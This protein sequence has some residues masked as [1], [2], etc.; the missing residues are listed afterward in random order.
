[1]C[2]LGHE[3]Q[4]D[5]EIFDARAPAN[6]PP[7]ENT[8]TFWCIVLPPFPSALP[9]L[10]RE[11]IRSVRQCKTSAEERALIAKESAAIRSSLKEDENSTR[12]RNVAKLMYMHMLGYP[13]HF[14]QMECVKLLASA[15]F[16]EKRVGYLGLMILLDER[17]EVTM[18]VTNSIKNDLRHKNRFVVGLALC[19][20]GSV[21]TAEMARDVAPE[22]ASLLRSDNSYVRKKAAL[23]AI[24][25][26][27]KVP[28]LRET[29]LDGAER[30]LTD[31]HH[32]VLLAAVALLLQ[33]CKRGEETTGNARDR[34]RDRDLDRDRDVILTRFREKVPE[35]VKILRALLHGAYGAEH[36]VGGQ[37]DPF[38]QVKILRL[39]TVLGTGDAKTSDLISDCLANVTANVSAGKNA[40]NAVLYEAVRCIIQTESV[41]GLRVLAVNVLGRFLADKDNN[42][43]YV[44][45]NALASVVSHDAAAVQ[46]HRR[47]IV[48][49]V[50]DSDI[51]IR[52]SALQLVYSLVNAQNV[53]TL[54]KE[55]L[56]YLAVADVEFKADVS[57]KIAGLCAKF[58]PSDRWRVDSFVQLLVRGGAHVKNEEC[59]SFLSL[60]SN[61]PEN[62]RAYACRALFRATHEERDHF[63]LAAVSAWVLGEY[64]DLAV[65]E[66]ARANGET[67]HRLD[68]EPPMI[69][70]ASDIVQTLRSVLTDQ[71]SP[72]SVK[73]IATTALTKC[74]ARF[75]EH[76]ELCRASVA[77]STRSIDLELQQRA[78]EFCS[79]F[80]MKDEGA[81]ANLLERM[82]P[83]PPRDDVGAATARTDGAGDSSSN[84]RA[85]A[86]SGD[87]LGDLLGEEVV[88]AT[89]GGSH[90]AASGADLL[91][92]LL[93]GGDATPGTLSE[94]PAGNAPDPLA[95]L[96]GGLTPPAPGAASRPT[97]APLDPMADLM[98]G[99]GGVGGVGGIGGIG[100]VGGPMTDLT[101]GIG[102]F[103][104]STTDLTNGSSGAFDPTADLLASSASAAPFLSAGGSALG[105]ALVLSVFS[106]HGVSATFSCVQPSSAARG[107]TTITATYENA[108][109]VP[110]TGFKVRAAVPTTST[111]A[112]EP[113]TSSVLAPA[114]GQAT[115]IL[116]AVNHQI[117]AGK[118]LAIR[119]QA[120]WRCGADERMETATVTF[121]PGF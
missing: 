113:A 60:L 54:I 36:D 37:H 55:L 13:T 76:A 110:V 118:T 114:G 67:P 109:D 112:L 95:A 49:C 115:Q 105:S 106:A 3:R 4:F 11:L 38:L 93:G 66:N 77:G 81:K 75:P 21:C 18:L 43:R 99:I 20:L 70:S 29:F 33:L 56:D 73:L 88:S 58:A 102:G 31:R 101:N 116:R 91:G 15:G 84:L 5:A 104:G 47:T 119:V 45:L 62:L 85:G 59:R 42:V 44:A 17:Q 68:G 83:M 19:A 2:I 65:T 80:D 74:A 1:M 63:Q 35:L 10:L 108:N 48:E 120:S 89:T 34:D 64:G 61:S 107:A 40:G 30:L 7:H 98:S 22:V 16:P 90:G 46:R 117:A 25:V 111:L 78:V 23:C 72:S 27:K 57:K 9:K 79:V 87:L 86:D 96:L 97:A 8:L 28:E 41:G 103:G 92:D 53:E 32:G 82:P 121:P 52:R 71:S 69:L 51:T 94:A 39:L 14:G 50:K 26:V 100:G 6:A 12:H 24:R